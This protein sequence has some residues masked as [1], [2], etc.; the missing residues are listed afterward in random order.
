MSGPDAQLVAR[1]RR[2]DRDAFGVLVAR[3]LRAAYRVAVA[4]TGEHDQAEDVCQDAFIAALRRLEDCRDPERFGPWLLA[5]VRNRARDLGRREARRATSPLEESLAAGSGSDPSDDVERSE[6]AASLTAAMSGLGRTQRAVVRLF[7]V[8]GMSHREIAA[9]LSI[10]EGT[11]R[12][13]LCH[14]R[15]TLRHRL[16]PLWGG[17][18]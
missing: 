4:C 15:R 5:I 16:E 2:G 18:S 13:A 8:E 10:T 6:L 7:D 1:A 12:V 9:R 3:H 11:A 14:A 17:A